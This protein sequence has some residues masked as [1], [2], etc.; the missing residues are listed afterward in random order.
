VIKY[1][2]G[3]KY[4]LHRDTKQQTNIFPIN[5]I[6]TTFIMHGMAHQARPLIPSQQ[7]AVH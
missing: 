2:K 4:Q 6:D 3:Y 7:C 5:D 1:R